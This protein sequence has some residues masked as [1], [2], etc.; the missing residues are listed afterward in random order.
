MGTE[1]NKGDTFR[2]LLLGKHRWGK[3]TCTKLTAWST[4][5]AGT[6]ESLCNCST[7]SVRNPWHYTGNCSPRYTHRRSCNNNR[8]NALPCTE[9]ACSRAQFSPESTRSR[10]GK[11]DKGSKRRNFEGS[12]ECISDQPRHPSEGWRTEGYS[13]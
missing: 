12:C 2:F 5:I 3:G 1:S 13:S 11:S 9:M 8:H 4:Q 6:S 7:H 10:E